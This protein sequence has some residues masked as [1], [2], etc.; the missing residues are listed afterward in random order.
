METNISITP[1][2]NRVGAF[3]LDGIILGIVGSII[4]YSFEDYFVSIGNNGLYVGLTIALLYFT[5]SNSRLLN[6]QT[7]GKRV[8]KIQVVDKEGNT[9]QID[10]SFYR[11]L[12]LCVPYFTINLNIPGISEGSSLYIIKSMIL[13]AILLGIIIIYSFNK[14]TRQSIHDLLVGSYVV[15]IARAETPAILPKVTKYAYYI[16]GGFIALMIGINLLSITAKSPSMG[17]ANKIYKSLS[18][19]DGIIQAGVSKNVHRL[20]GKEKKVT[21]S[22]RTT[23]R[24]AKLPKNLNNIEKEKIVRLA[25]KTILN[26]EPTINNVDLIVI[27]LTKGFNIGIAKSNFSYSIGKTPSE[28]REILKNE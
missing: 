16:W 24:V 28:W 1:F 12:I 19:I 7:L 22:I 20:Y 13:F 9:L 23:L 5:I 8:L 27:T 10:K 3:F 6:G 11:A 25:A 26:E 14:G 15:S 21:H 18:K 4:G 17:S 2:I